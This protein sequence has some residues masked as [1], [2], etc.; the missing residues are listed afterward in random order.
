MPYRL[1]H[2]VEHPAEAGEPRSVSAAEYMPTID[3]G[4]TFDDAVDALTR[5]TIGLGRSLKRIEGGLFKHLPGT[6]GVFVEEWNDDK[7]QQKHQIWLIRL[8]T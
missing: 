8:L 4:P 1:Q 3:Y 6:E 5:H 7:R 2:G